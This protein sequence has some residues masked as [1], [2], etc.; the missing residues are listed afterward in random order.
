MTPASRGDVA[1]VLPVVGRLATLF[2]RGR[3]RT[4]MTVRAVL[5]GPET[6]VTEALEAEGVVFTRVTGV[7]SADAVREAG[8]ADADLFL[9]TDPAEATAVGV[10]RE[11]NPDVRIVASVAETL[12]EYARPATDLVVDPALLDPA[13][14]AEE[15]VGVAEGTDPSERESAA[16]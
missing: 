4:S 8:I 14:V 5:V 1:R 6:A 3:L 2:S 13:V 16:E 11:A 7:P 9:L 12:P 15:V 10:V